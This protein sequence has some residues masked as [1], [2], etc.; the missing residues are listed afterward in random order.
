M[1]LGVGLSALGVCV[2]SVSGSRSS[3]PRVQG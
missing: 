1:F 2:G 3:G